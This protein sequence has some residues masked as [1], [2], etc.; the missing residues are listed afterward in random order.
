MVILFVSA[1]TAALAVLGGLHWYAW[2][3][4]VRDTTA[5]PERSAGRARPCS[6]PDRS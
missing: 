6:S 1:G 3:R 2:R 5:A 4:L